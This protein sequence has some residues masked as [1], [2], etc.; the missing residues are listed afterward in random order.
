MRL[1][2]LLSKSN[3]CLHLDKSYCDGRR[4]KQS[5]PVDGCVRERSRQPPRDSM[6]HV[7]LRLVNVV[8]RQKQKL[9]VFFVPA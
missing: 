8:I 7:L 1:D 9:V 6:G 2:E 4:G 3:P 5:D